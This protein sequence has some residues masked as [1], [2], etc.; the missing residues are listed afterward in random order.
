MFKFPDPPLKANYPDLNY[1]RDYQQAYRLGYD[2]DAIYDPDVAFEEI[3]PELK[4]NWE[5]S[6]AESRLSWDEAKLASRDA[7]NR[8]RK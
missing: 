6:R 2:N 7:W 3:E 4:V 8:N 5:K 1:E